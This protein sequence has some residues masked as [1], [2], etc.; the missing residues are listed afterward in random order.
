[1]IRT[2]VLYPI[3]AR[4]CPSAGDPQL[5]HRLK[6]FGAETAYGCANLHAPLKLKLA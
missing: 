4:D 1:M 3:P 2:G 5:V 6:S